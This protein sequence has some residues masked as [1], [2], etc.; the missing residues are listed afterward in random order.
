MSEAGK[1]LRS[2]C[3]SHGMKD[4]CEELLSCS[5]KESC[6]FSLI[7]IAF[8]VSSVQPYGGTGLTLLTSFSCQDEGAKQSR[9]PSLCS[10]RASNPIEAG[11]RGQMGVRI[12]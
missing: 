6:V 10:G 7:F 8:K 11:A 12:C 3:V 1:Q 5:S 2:H 4:A 9:T